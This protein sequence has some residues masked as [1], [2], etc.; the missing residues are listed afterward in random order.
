[1]RT[2]NISLFIAVSVV[3]FIIYAWSSAP[4][5]GLV[6]SGEL[7]A[8]AWNLGIAH[9]TG[10]PLFTLLGRVWLSIYPGS[11]DRGMVL[12]SA[13]QGALA[14]GL[15]ALLAGIII[16]NAGDFGALSRIAA[17]GVL[18]VSF[19]LTKSAWTSISYTE[20]YPLTW[21]IV[22]IILWLCV[23]FS[24]S[25]DADF[26]PVI[27]VL[28]IFFL[29]G[30][31]FG[32]HLTILW[33]APLILW[34]IVV[35]ARRYCSFTEYIWGAGG[36]FLLG[37]S[38]N[39][40]LTVRSN[41]E[42]VLDW[43]D[44]QTL[45]NLI[46]HLSA[47]Q[48]RV[49]M[50]NGNLGTFVEKI[51]NYFINIP[52]DI[53]WAIFL[54][55]MVGIVYSIFKRIGLGITML[56][57]WLLGTAYN[58]NYDIPD[59]STY[60]LIFY[61]PLFVL[62]LYGI[63]PILR[64]INQRS[65]RSLFV[66]IAPVALAVVFVISSAVSAGNSALARHDRFATDF[67]KAIVDPLPDNSVVFQGN[68]DIQSPLIYLQEVEHYRP[69]IVMLDINLMQRSWYIKQQRRR[70]PQVF[71]TA[72]REVTVFLRAVEPFERGK[73]FNGPVIE[74][75]FVAM[76]HAL[77]RNQIARHPVYLRDMVTSGHP[78]IG[79]GFTQIPGAY[80]LRIA[81]PPASEPVLNITSL[82]SADNLADDR[83]R[84]L[85][86]QAALSTMLQGRYAMGVA[87]TVQLRR[88]VDECR[89]LTPVE[90][91]ISDFISI[92][93]EYLSKDQQTSHE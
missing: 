10:Y 36:L 65:S 40:F 86:Q 16:R 17:S 74:N 37:A 2:Y 85:L 21:L 82:I 84:F 54:F 66:R 53:G 33:Y 70:H 26:H 1:M 45:S 19:A 58:L 67:V 93:E 27:A 13:L 76:H 64:K 60:F 72:D 3:V 12:L 79:S 46:R 88:I 56:V 9:P 90:P 8:V 89:S 68:W 73:P 31:G 18:A 43:G 7:T 20:V 57:I 51:V 5:I 83:K 14:C 25:T 71:E 30:I 42:P 91:R 62:S 81:E 59:I 32:N 78:K 61:C 23:R 47:W 55:A 87:D 69:D 80:F 35:T 44:P 38:I 29:W 92:A 11:P 4:G 48:Y 52:A 15:F 49:W 6:D 24:D 75:A 41:V 63:M 34:L 77:I 22:S 28:L 39:I 50:F